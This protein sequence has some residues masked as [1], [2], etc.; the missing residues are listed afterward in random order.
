MINPKSMMMMMMR[1]A[2]HHHHHHRFPP[3]SSSPA[4]PLSPPLWGARV[5]E[6]KGEKKE[7]K[8]REKS[9]I[10]IERWSAR[11]LKGTTPITSLQN[12]FPRRLLSPKQT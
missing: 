11:D 9:E 12:G 2:H 3:V 10:Y 1:T 5:C 7:E 6:P 8:D 4:S